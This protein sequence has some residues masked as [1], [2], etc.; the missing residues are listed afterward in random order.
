MADPNHIG[1]QSK[2]KFNIKTWSC[3]QRNWQ[4]KSATGATVAASPCC[5]KKR[6]P[7]GVQ[8][9]A[10]GG[11]LWRSAATV[12]CCHV[13]LAPGVKREGDTS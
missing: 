9:E 11:W 7:A 1:G 6:S 4:L 13:R 12:R 3:E 2:G 5:S 10:G 8:S